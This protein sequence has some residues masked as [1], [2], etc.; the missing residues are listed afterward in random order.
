MSWSWLPNAI[1][2]ARVLASLPLLWLLMRGEYVAAFWL[3]W[4][5]FG[6]V[7]IAG[8]LIRGAAILVTWLLATAGFGAALLSRAGLRENFAGRL[9]PPEALTDEYL[10]A[11][12]Q[13]GV[14][15]A[16]RPGHR[17]PTRGL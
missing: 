15:A 11:T 14:T 1:T 9:I 12:P 17:T 5:V 10:W 8:D 13:F 7:P 3:A 4:S 16:K 6:W 2:L